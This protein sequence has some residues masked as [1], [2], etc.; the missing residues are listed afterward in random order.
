MIV[1][2]P[3]PDGPETTTRRAPGAPTRGAPPGDPSSARRRRASSPGD[4]PGRRGSAGPPLRRRRLEHGLELGRERRLDA[5]ESTRS[6]ATANSSRQAWR[7]SRSRPSGPR[8]ARSRAVDRVAR[9]RVAERGEVDPDLVGP[10]GDEVE[11]EE[12]PAGEALAD[13]VAGDGRSTVGDHGHPLPVLRVATDRRLDPAE[14][15]PRRVPG[16]GRGTSSS[17]GGP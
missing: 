14:R 17:P 16:R 7:N 9:D 13:P 3:T 12:R 8:R 10:P 11:L 4:R 1:S 5:D 15:P 6:T 2:L